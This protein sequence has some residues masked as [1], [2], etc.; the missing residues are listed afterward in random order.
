VRIRKP[1][2]VHRLARNRY[3]CMQLFGDRLKDRKI[4]QPPRLLGKSPW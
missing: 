1:T 2:G 3:A 4:A